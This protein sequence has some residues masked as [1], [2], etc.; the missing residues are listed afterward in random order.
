MKLSSVVVQVVRPRIFGIGFTSIHIL[1]PIAVKTL[2]QS[3]PW[4]LLNEDFDYVSLSMIYDILMTT[5][6][7]CSYRGNSAPTIHCSINISPYL[8]SIVTT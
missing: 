6:G 4:I 5:I 7:S 1:L 3:F 8:R 2:I